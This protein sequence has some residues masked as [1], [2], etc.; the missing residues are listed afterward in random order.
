SA[1]ATKSTPAVIGPTAGD[2]LKVTFAK[3]YGQKPRIMITPNDSASA[4]LLVYAPGSATASFNLS[5]A[6][7]PQ[8]NTTY[9]FTYYVVQ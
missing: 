9:S 4:K 8:S 1:P 5:V 6:A 7:P 2:L 3:A